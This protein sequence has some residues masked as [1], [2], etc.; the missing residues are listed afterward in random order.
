MIGIFAAAIVLLAATTGANASERSLKSW[1]SKAS[2]EVVRYYVA[3][4][5]ATRAETW[6]RKNGATDAQIE[7]ARR[8]LIKQRWA[9][10]TR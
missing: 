9:N 2:C 1:F 4:Y 10:S 6:A 7:S 5:S 3:K 8:C